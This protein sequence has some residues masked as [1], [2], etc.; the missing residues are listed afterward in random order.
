[1]RL[2]RVR[3]YDALCETV[4]AKILD[5]V[6]SGSRV[7]L[8]LAT[9]STPRGIYSRLVED[10]RVNGTSYRRVH[11]FNLDEYVG[12]SPKAPESYHHYM[13]EALF[14]HVDFPRGGTHLPDGTTANLEE[15]CRKYEA[16]I[17]AAGG[18]DLQLLGI[19]V[20]GHIGFNEPG[21][22]FSSRTHVV[23]LAESTRRANRRFFDHP[24][25][26]PKR[27]ITMGVATIMDSREIFL[28]ASGSDKAEIVAR[29]LNEEVSES[30][31]ASVLKRHPQ[32]TMIAEETAL[33]GLSAVGTEGKHA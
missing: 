7:N 13:E 21:T 27:A 18:I 4:V 28:M 14:R 24:H 3:D 25:N 12:L 8:G 33:A 32:A 11:T 2:I 31:P 10:A 6:Q 16:A 22:S 20:N 29:L 30:L 26:V 23:T 19:G 17:Q 1:M 9:G 15:E 5:R